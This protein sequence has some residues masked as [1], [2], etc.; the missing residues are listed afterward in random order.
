M[1][2][3]NKGIDMPSICSSPSSELGDVEP[4]REQVQLLLELSLFRQALAEVHRRPADPESLR[5][6]GLVMQRFASHSKH[7]DCTY[8]V[9]RGLYRTAA[10]HTRDPLLHAELRADIGSSYFEEG[11]LDDAVHEL[12][13]SR[14]LAPWKYH[15]HLALLAIA[16]ATRVLPA[17]RRRCE[18]L[19]GDIP[20]W[21]ANREVVALLVTDPDFAF[22][23]ASPALF[24]ECFGGYPEQLRALHDRYSMEALERA[25][26]DTA[27]SD[28]GTEP[29][30]RKR[31]DRS[32]RR[33][34][35][36]AFK[37]YIIDR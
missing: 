6:L 29:I 4:H 33:R 22:L 35:N 15:A 27:V 36:A 20:C 24:L 34:C 28:R 32:M 17:I 7:R 19:V 23:R 14:A 1:E 30:R 16:C 37:N 2:T 3:A 25:L 26:A 10:T 8:M 9:A 18:D 31:R 12:E 21:Y 11:R 5:Q 13:T